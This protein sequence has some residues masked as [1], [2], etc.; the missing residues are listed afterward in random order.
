[1]GGRLRTGADLTLVTGGAR[2]G[3]SRYALSLVSA[4]RPAIYIATAEALDEDMVGRIARHRAERPTA[5]STVEAPI[6]LA[7]AVRQ[8]PAPHPIIVDCLTLWVS[9][10]LLRDAPPLEVRDPW[11]PA[12][13]V[14]DLVEALTSR[15]PAVIVVT[16]EVGLGIVPPTALGRT[17]RDALG[18]INQRVAEVASRVTLL[19]AG[20]PVAIKG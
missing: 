4:E 2:A 17:Y 15:Q 12:A 11:Y 10:L 7:T 3:K 14:D 1:V 8:A 9:N 19:V 20:L 5:W 13:I 18:R 6:E 16:N